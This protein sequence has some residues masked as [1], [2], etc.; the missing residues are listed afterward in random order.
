[1]A[2]PGSAHGA[3]FVPATA[4]LISAPSWGI[5][6]VF[7]NQT[8]AAGLS[9]AIHDSSGFSNASYSGGGVVGDFNNDGF[10]D[11]FMPS[12]GDL[13]K[14]DYLFINNGDGTFTDQATAWGLTT[15]HKG[16]GCTVGDFNNDGWL[17]IY[18]TSAG[19]SVGPSAPGHHKLYMNNGNGTFT[20]VAAAAGVNTTNASV[21]DGWGASFGDYDRDGDLDLMVGGSSSNNAGSKLFRN[22]GDGTFTNVTGNMFNGVPGIFGFSPSIIDMNDDFWP[23]IPFTGDFGS[24]RYFRNNTNGTFTEMSAAAGTAKE[25]NGMGQCFGD[26]NNDGR[27]DWYVTSIYLP[28]TGWTGNKIYRN[29][30]NHNYTEYSAGAGVVD[31]GYGWGSVA[32]DFNHD[33]WLDIGE[34]NGDGASSGQFFNEQ[35]YLWVAN[36]SVNTFTEKALACGLSHF[37]KGRCMIHFDADNDGDQDVLIFAN[38]Q[39]LTYFRN[40]LPRQADTKWLRVFLDTSGSSLPPNGIGSRIS[41]SAGGKTYY[42]FV[43]TA[44]TFLGTNELSGHF[45]LGSN[46]GADVVSVRWADGSTKVLTNVDLNQTITIHAVDPPPACPADLN[47]SGSVDGADLG[48]LL[49]LWGSDDIEADINDD[50]IVDGADLGL[51]LSAWGDEC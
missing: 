48:L 41:V 27:I 32:V 8:A 21:S 6:P 20:N 40:D 9:S 33:G 51:L 31:G 45:G 22:N 34:T 29:N 28:S 3:L 49:A 44:P 17:D 4:L 2:I 5:D 43:H 13:S 42:R 12:G 25:E 26:F 18:E 50:G 1:M 24:S 23:D 11:I 39:A 30:G 16:K 7:T 46:T 19:P 37:G 10:Q 47:A 35:S 38:N 14:L 15:P 36:P